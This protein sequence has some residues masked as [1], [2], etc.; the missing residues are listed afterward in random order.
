L[1]GTHLILAFLR[2][3]AKMSRSISN[4]E[5]ELTIHQQLGELIGRFG[6]AIEIWTVVCLSKEDF[7][8]SRLFVDEQWQH[9][10]GGIQHLRKLLNEEETSTPAVHDQLFKIIGC[11]T[12]LREVFDQLL[13]F[14]RIS[15]RDL[16]LSIVRLS[17]LWRSFQLRI[18][19]LAVLV[20]LPAPLPALTSEQESYYQTILDG[21]FDRFVAARPIS[22]LTLNRE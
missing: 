3:D 12:Q 14:D 5:L 16:E 10:M 4:S 13:D 18:S 2:N 22:Y 15:L 20:P 19:L 21:L 7:G 11:C 17:S 6:A 8:S 1:F 9:L